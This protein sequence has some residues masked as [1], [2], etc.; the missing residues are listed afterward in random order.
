MLGTAWPGETGDPRMDVAWKTQSQE[1]KERYEQR[2]WTAE[3]RGISRGWSISGSFREE[4]TKKTNPQERAGVVGGVSSG[5]RN[6]DSSGH[7][8][9]IKEDWWN[10]GWESSSLTCQLDPGQGGT[11]GGWRAGVSTWGEQC[12]EKTLGR[13]SC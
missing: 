8:G 11:T 13:A 5:G 9:V 3:E 6:Q 1:G 4:V 7:L 2:G 12:L 10:G